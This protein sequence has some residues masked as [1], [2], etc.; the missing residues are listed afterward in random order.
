MNPTSLVDKFIPASDSRTP[1]ETLKFRIIIGASLLG[2]AFAAAN[3]VIG[4][5]LD[6]PLPNLQIILLLGCIISIPFLAK[7]RAPY[8]ALAHILTCCTIMSIATSSLGAD[9]RPIL[10]WMVVVPLVANFFIGWRA[11]LIYSGIAFA[12]IYYAGWA[13]HPNVLDPY[14]LFT[15]AM[16]LVAISFVTGLYT[17]EWAKSLKEVDVT[18]NK[19]AEANNELITNLQEIEIKNVHLSNAQNKIIHAS[20]MSALGTMVAGIAHEINNPL[21]GIHGHTQFLIRKTD[22]SQTKAILEKIE[23]CSGRIRDIIKQLDIFEEHDSDEELSIISVNE[24]LA[25]ITAEQ[26]A[27][28]SQEGI[29]IGHTSD[30]NSPTIKGAP[31]KFHRIITNL[32]TN[33]IKAIQ[34][35]VDPSPDDFVE[36][37]SRSSGDDVTIY[38]RDSGPGVKPSIAK[39]I[40][41]P[42]FTTREPGKGIGMGLMIVYEFLKEMGGTIDLNQDYQNGAEFCILLPTVEKGI[43]L[44]EESIRSYP[45]RPTKLAPA[46]QE[47]RKSILLI[48]D[49]ESIRE[50][51]KLILADE[52]DLTVA[53]TGPEGLNLLKNGEYSILLSDLNL[54]GVSGIEICDVALEKGMKGRIILVTGYLI[55]REQ[56]QKL[57]EAGVTM[58][59]K[60]FN[61]NNLENTIRSLSTGA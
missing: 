7:M 26:Q 21:T 52:Y 32:I 31:T 53:Q 15:W 46:P 25:E 58:I 57:E 41:D 51:L 18:K 61:L 54:P 9:A 29:L 13:S 36:V 5:A 19:L 42:F 30:P 11:T 2:T 60:P 40:F 50:Y 23:N 1:Q 33:A 39:Y 22:S 35:R 37:G 6:R 47:G 38:V 43:R 20:K 55:G 48:E 12:S 10:R 8:L 24:V 16:I 56:K 34:E 28:Y 3:L 44:P 45:S 4:F 27:I 17:K 49:D 14:N 59:L